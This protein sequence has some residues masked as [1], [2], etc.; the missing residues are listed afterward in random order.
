M[1]SYTPLPAALQVNG[2]EKMKYMPSWISG[3][4]MGIL[5]PQRWREYNPEDKS[6]GPIAM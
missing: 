4:S 5:M 6:Q 2:T 3:F 1:Y